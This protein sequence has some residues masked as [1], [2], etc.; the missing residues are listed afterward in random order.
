MGYFLP[1]ATQDKEKPHGKKAGRARED[2]G[3][4]RSPGRAGLGDVRVGSS[5]PLPHPGVGVCR[6][7]SVSLGQVTCGGT[8]WQLL[9]LWICA[10][11]VGKSFRDPWSVSRVGVSP[12]VMGAAGEGVAME[13][14]Q[15]AQFFFLTPA[16]PHVWCFLQIP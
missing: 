10:G 5:C 12:P 4:S 6:C 9:W 8:A 7:S 13:Q 11:A 16:V 15:F 1:E 2:S 3:S 14:E